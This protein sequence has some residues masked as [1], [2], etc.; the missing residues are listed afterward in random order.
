MYKLSR[1]FL[2]VLSVLIASAS[3]FAQWPEYSSNPY[4]FKIEDDL[5]DLEATMIV[6]DLNND[7]L[8]DFTFRTSSILYAYDHYGAF[9]WKQTIARPGNNAGSKHGIADVD[10]DGVVEVVALDTSDH[11]VVF[12]GRTGSIEQSIPLVM[13]NEYQFASHIAI[14]NFRG[15]GRRDALVQTADVTIERTGL[16]Y[17]IN[18]SL[19]AINLENGSEIWTQHVVQDRDL[20]LPESAPLG[21]YE[22]YWGQAHGAFLSADVD[23]D[24]HDEVIGGNMVESDGTVVDLG[25]PRD[26]IEYLWTP[27][28][29]WKHTEFIDHLDAITVGDFRPDI[30]G[31]EWAVCEE[32]HLGSVPSWETSMLHYDSMAPA[33]GLL[34]QRAAHIDTVGE[35][36]EAQ[37]LAGGNFSMD[38]SNSEMYNRSRYGDA[39]HTQHPWIY[40]QHGAMIAHYTTVETLPEDFH[41]FAPGFNRNGIEMMWTIDWA[42]SK[43]EYIA[44]KARHV[45]DNVGVFNAMTGEAVWSTGVNFDPVKATTIYVADVAG[46][47]REEVVICDS[48]NTGCYIRVYWNEE[49]NT[50]QP[51]PRKWDDPL[52]SHVKQNYNYYSPGSYTTPDYPEISQL[53][54]SDVTANGF[55]VNWQTDEP[56]TSQVLWGLTESLGQQSILDEDLVFAH[57]VRISGLS[58]DTPYFYQIKSVSAHQVT[59]LSNISS[60]STD[61]AKKLKITSSSFSVYANVISPQ[62]TVELQNIEGE[63]RPAATDLTV[64]LASTSSGG[65]FSLSAEPWS[66]VTQVVIP[67]GASQCQFY[68]RDSQSGTSDLTPAETP[69]MGWVHEGRSITVMANGSSHVSHRVYGTLRTTGA[70]VPADGQLAFQAVLSGA[71]AEVLTQ[72]SSACGYHEGQWYID[73]ANFPS[74]WQSG[75]TLTVN[76]SDGGS[77]EVGTL[78][79]TL[80]SQTTQNGGETVLG[81]EAP[82]F[83]QIEVVNGNQIRLSWNAIDGVTGYAVYR[84]SAATFIPDKQGGSNRI[85]NT[86]TDQ[87]G[88]LAGVQWT[89]VNAPVAVVATHGFYRVTAVNSHGEGNYSSVV[90]EIDYPLTPTA[91]T[92]FNYIG[93]PLWPMAG[94]PAKASDLKGII[95]HCDGVS[96]WNSGTQTFDLY[97]S[98]PVNDFAVEAG[99]AYLVNTPQSGVFTLTGTVVAGSYALETTGGTDFNAVLI[100]LDRPDLTLASRLLADIDGCN[101]VA[102]W[103]TAGQGFDQYIPQIP[104]TDFPL[105]AGYPYLVNVTRSATWPSGSGKVVPGGASAVTGLQ[106]PHLVWGDIDGGEVPVDFEAWLEHEPEDRLTAAST[107]CHLDAHQWRVQCRSFKHGWSLNDRMMLRLKLADGRCTAVT[108]V[109]LTGAP[110]DQAEGMTTVGSTQ[111]PQSFQMDD[112]YPNPFNGE[113]HFD[114]HLPADGQHAILIYDVRGRLV[115]TLRDGMTP[116]GSYGYS[117]DGRDDSGAPV[118][119]GVYLIVA[120]ADRARQTM[121]VMLLQ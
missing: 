102:R 6:F 10:G 20:N 38:Y 9:M 116:A 17:Y 58:A 89:D 40:D 115:R 52:Y 69:D 68:Y 15:Q 29:Q 101:S 76:F 46:D 60:V 24:G 98:L 22:G 119:T 21:I 39:V 51:K 18:R 19:I 97:V 35:W 8:P 66:A 80:D 53:S 93:L 90:G 59:G 7:G 64:D 4:S 12:D 1:S 99:G 2:F 42:G 44:A 57:A 3:S 111:L 61:F 113:T 96:A 79:L 34:W 78:I 43:L 118:S 31:I 14:V 100:P 67:Q 25:Y 92:D 27:Y 23:L 95:P 114:V 56:A 110:A 55:T 47:N 87:N 117:W 71:P 83:S 112:N 36:L 28:E 49:S 86:I 120:Q 81:L 84:G 91:S 103:T 77:G 72:T 73:C 11:V 108:S 109:K 48:T 41:R 63:A 74:G 65:S 26:W 121:K 54:I 75:R 37:N 45:H 13:D 85:A 107:G 70:Q 30:P 94:A 104:A 32:D 50:H 82:V 105:A 88:A 62:V 5:G 106:A 33:S 16:P